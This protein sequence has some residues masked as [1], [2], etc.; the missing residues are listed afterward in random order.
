MDAFFNALPK[1]TEL[2]TVLIDENYQKVPD[3]WFVVAADVRGSTDAIEQGRYRDVNFIGAAV[4]TAFMTHVSPDLPYCFGGDGATLLIKEEML[5]A[6]ERVLKSLCFWSESSFNLELHAGVI[7]I[8]ELRSRGAEVEVAIYKS[9][10]RFSQVMFKGGGLTLAEKLIKEDSLLRVIPAPL[11]QQT[12]IFAGLSCRWRPVRASK[13]VTLCM[14]I[15]PPIKDSSVLSTFVQ[16]LES[17]LGGSVKLSNP[18]S[19]EAARYNSFASNMRRQIKVSG[20]CLNKHFI[21][22]MFEL[23]ITLFAFNLGLFRLFPALKN[24]ISKLPQ[25]CDFQKYDDTLRLVLDCSPQQSEKIINILESHALN[26]AIAYG[27]HA[28]D[29]AQMTCYVESI[30]D[31]GHL[32]FVDGSDGG[33]ALAAKMLKQQLTETE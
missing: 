1:L 17:I 2:N 10:D 15:A 5:E 19:M 14:L 3:D 28:S 32:H 6:S 13:G 30:S 12:E 23:L 7:P 25:H 4:I 21:A 16:E 24:Y 9:A 18:I 33:Y 27:V 22:N 8:S 20:G 26:G 29:A 31:G 11:M